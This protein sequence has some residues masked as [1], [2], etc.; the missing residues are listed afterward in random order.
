MELFKLFG[1]IFIKNAS[2]N[3]AIK[4]TTDKAEGAGSKIVSAF[5]KIGGA[6]VAYMAVDKIKDFGLAMIDA[7]SDANAMESQFTQVFGDMESNASSSLSAIAEETGV[8][9]N[10]MKG[11][12]T[13]IAAFAKT[14]GMDTADA[15]D[16]ANRSMIAVADSAAFYDRSL[17]ETTETLQSFLKG[18][19]END[20]A[21]GISCTETTRNTKANE[22]YGKSFQDLSEAQKQ[23]T[24]LAM[25]EDANKLSG[26]M[27]QA[28]RESDTWT[29]QTGNL[30]QAWQDF[31]AIIGQP[32]LEAVIPIVQGLVEVVQGLAVG[33][34]ALCGWVQSV[35]DWFSSA[36]EW[37]ANHKTQLEY[38]AIAVGTLTTAIIAYNAA[39]AIKH[40][41]GIAELAQL[42]LLQVQLWGLTAAQTAQTVA[43]NIAT[44]ATTAFGAVMSFITHPVTL[45]VVAIGALIAIVKLLVDNW[46][47]VSK[48]AKNA[49]DFIVNVFQK[50]GEWFN[51]T[52]VQPIASFFSGLWSGIKNGASETWGMVKDGFSTLT[53]F[54]SGL[55]SGITD[56]CSNAWTKIKDMFG[57]VGVAIADGIT[58]AVKSAV[59]GVL[60][61]AISIINGFINAINF[62]IGAINAIP[63]VSISKLSQLEVP[64]L[65][66][67]GVLE[68]GQI[69]L[70]EGNGAEAVVP[71]D[72]NQKWIS[73]VAQD[74]ESAIGGKQQ[75]EKLDK[76]I[77]LMEKILG[78][79]PEVMDGV[80][81]G[82][83]N[84]EFARLVRQV[85]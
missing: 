22:L 12:Y 79:I 82:I 27:G 1:T 61:G 74:M 24:L 31:L 49:W 43:T 44:A 6:V 32:V 14:S 80:S 42:A 50:A 33:Y 66:E 69:G 23:L 26:A 64:Q 55:W 19:Y 77:E 4:D 35:I 41:G 83:N 15:L 71:L 52:V 25:V 34:E 62:A 54:F 20:S 85:N 53:S 68:K 67:G 84:R 56:I 5:K 18:N 11:S 9:E 58:G 60:S 39:N 63:G 40:A 51:N 37:L 46:D 8:L 38:V 45:V 78:V 30:K 57:K 59:N 47:V 13:K 21:L 3:N 7:A 10:R 72:Q 2:A 48:A 81:L 76:M 36:S 16:L 29:N 75:N 73:K 28:S 70:L 17:E 65:E